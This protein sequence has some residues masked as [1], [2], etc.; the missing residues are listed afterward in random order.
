V[1]GR[2]DVQLIAGNTGDDLLEEI[3]ISREILLTLDL[4]TEM[5]GAELGKGVLKRSAANV[6]LVE[7]LHGSEACSAALIGATIG[8][9]VA[10]RVIGHTSVVFHV[11]I[12]R[13]QSRISGLPCDIAV[14]GAGVECS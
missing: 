4:A 11:R 9:R 14:R 7:R 12:G 5:E 13:E 10:F 8:G 3:S 2:V 1:H 6:H